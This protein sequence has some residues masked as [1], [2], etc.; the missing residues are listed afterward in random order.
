M[1]HYPFE[2]WLFEEHLSLEEQK[3]LKDHLADCVDCRELR[4][5]INETDQLF[6]NLSTG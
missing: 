2:E 4:T 6:S 3:Q 1:N 5:A